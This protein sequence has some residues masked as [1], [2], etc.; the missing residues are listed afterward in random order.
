M[1]IDIGGDASGTVR[2]LDCLVDFL[3]RTWFDIRVGRIDMLLKV[4]LGNVLI[5]MR[6][7]NLNDVITVNLTH[8]SSIRFES[9][10]RACNIES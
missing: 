1:P 10:N 7:F 5:A 9:T 8:L 6:T 4:L 3:V 2:A